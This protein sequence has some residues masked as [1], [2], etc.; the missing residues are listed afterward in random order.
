LND[1][2][3]E[4][5]TKQEDWIRLFETYWNAKNREHEDLRNLLQ[6]I[7]NAMQQVESTIQKTRKLIEN[8]LQSNDS[9]DI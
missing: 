3:Q 8:H 2:R 6:E 7:H 9:A 1:C 5:P 4:W